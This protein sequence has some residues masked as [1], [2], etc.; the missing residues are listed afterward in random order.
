MPLMTTGMHLAFDFG[1]IRQPRRFHDRKRI[2]AGPMPMR[3]PEPVR[4]SLMK[5]PRRSCRW[6]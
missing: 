4:L 6:Q 2:H 3:R 1:G 5:R